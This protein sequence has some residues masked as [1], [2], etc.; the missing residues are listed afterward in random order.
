MYCCKG[1]QNPRPIMYV[2][3]AKWLKANPSLIEVKRECDLV[4]TRMIVY[5]P[6]QPCWFAMVAN[7]PSVGK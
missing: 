6:N 1:A 4:Q 7:R 3:V 5:L 2:G